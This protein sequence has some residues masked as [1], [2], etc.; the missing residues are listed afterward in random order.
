MRLL[1]KLLCDVSEDGL[2]NE[3]N[4]RKSRTNGKRFVETGEKSLEI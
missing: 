4:V 2:P 3:Q 1:E